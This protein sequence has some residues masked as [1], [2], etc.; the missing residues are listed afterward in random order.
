MNDLPEDCE[1]EPESAYSGQTHWVRR[2]G[3]SRSTRMNDLLF[4]SARVFAVL[5]A[6]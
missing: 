1:K 2:N 4:S 3:V 5:G 6:L